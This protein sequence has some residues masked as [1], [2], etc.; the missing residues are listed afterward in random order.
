MPLNENNSID[1]WRNDNPVCPY[2]DKV[3]NI[4]EN[5]LWELYYEE[6]HSVECPFC[7]K[8]FTV[9]SSATWKFSSEYDTEE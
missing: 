8:F 4:S 3:V 7:E 9:I 1:Y 5:E 6:G 2:C